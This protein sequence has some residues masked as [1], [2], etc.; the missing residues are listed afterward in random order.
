M[1]THDVS[2]GL[3]PAIIRLVLRNPE[4]RSSPIMRELRTLG[5]GDRLTGLSDEARSHVQLVRR[6]VR[7]PLAEQARQEA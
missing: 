2:K 7:L 3:E 5:L 6:I 4:M 1:Q